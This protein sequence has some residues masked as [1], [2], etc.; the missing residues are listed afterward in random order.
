LVDS[1][2]EAAVRR[3]Q[4]ILDRSA[5]GLRVTALPRP[6]RTAR[7]AARVL[8]CG[9]GC[10]V[11]SLVFRGRTTGR[12]YLVATSGAHRVDAARL[13]GLTG[14]PVDQAPPDFVAE[15]TGFTPGGVSPVGHPRPLETII[16]MDLL[17]RP[18]VWAA[19]GSESA[20]FSL[21]PSQLVAITGGRIACVTSDSQQE[22]AQTSG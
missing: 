2:E 13:E 15:Q 10:I 12:A 3:V 11:K 22:T 18:T 4:A 5:S 8:G 17:N 19:A 21:T 9:I 6:A 20:M 14:E 7:D 1:G 16:D